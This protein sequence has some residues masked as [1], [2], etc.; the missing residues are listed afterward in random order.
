MISDKDVFDIQK[1]VLSE[2]RSF[3]KR[4]LEDAGGEDNIFES[5]QGR[6]LLELMQ[7]AD[8]AQTPENEDIV[9]K[10][11]GE[12]Q[13]TIILTEGSLYCANGGYPITKEGLEAIC[14][15]FV[16]PKRKN[17]PVI[18]FKGIGFKSILAVTNTP[19]IYW[20]DHGIS[21]SKDKTLKLFEENFPDVL[22]KNNIKEVPVLRFPHMLDFKIEI[23]NDHI[24]K[25]LLSDHATVFKF[26]FKN[27]RSRE[28]AIEKLKQIDSRIL[29]FLNSISKIV[30]NTWETETKVIQITKEDSKEESNERERF[31]ELNA[32]IF[33]NDKLSVWTVFNYVSDLPVS[34]KETLDKKWKD[35]DSISVS[36]AVPSFDGIYRP[37]D[38]GSVLHVYFPTEQRVP[39]GFLL[40]GTFRTNLDRRL[41]VDDDP[42]NDFIFDKGLK[43]IRKK[44]LPKLSEKLSDPGAILDFLRLPENVDE[45]TTEGR[46]WGKL[47]SELGD[48]RFI[49]P[50]E[51]DKKI[52]PENAMISPL[53]KDSAR[54]KSLMP[55]S[56]V[57]R[58]CDDTIDSDIKRRETIEAMGGYVYEFSAL[59]SLFEENFKEDSKWIG[60]MYAVL[61]KAYTY[62]QE[63]APYET[64]TEFLRVCRASNLLFTSDGERI[65]ADYIGKEGHIYFPSAGKLIDPPEGISIRF[66]DK[67][68]FS[69]YLSVISKPV[70]ETF[71]YK[72]MEVDEYSAANIILRTVIPKIAEFWENWPESKAFEPLEVLKFLNSIFEISD[73]AIT[74]QMRNLR[75]MPV[76][77]NDLGDY[78]EASS[79]YASKY[80]TG[81]DDLEVIYGSER[82]FLSQPD[83][84][85]EEES[86]AQLREVFKTLG[87]SFLPRVIS[88]EQDR[89]NGIAYFWDWGSH[90]FT[91]RHNVNI[92][93]WAEYCKDIYNDSKEKGMSNPFSYYDLYLDSFYSL[94][95]FDE[96]SRDRE[97]AQRLLTVL[98]HNLN[99]YF[100]KMKSKVLCREKSAR[101]YYPIYIESYLS[102]RLKNKAWVPTERFDLWAFKS[103][104]DLFVKSEGAYQKL[105]D[106]L[107]AIE[108]EDKQVD[109]LLTFLDVRRGI[110]SVE[111]RDWWRIAADLPRLLLPNEKEVN[112]IY[113]EMLNAKGMEHDCDEKEN[114][115]RQGKILAKIDG[116]YDFV[117]R[118]LVWYIEGGELRTLFED[119]IPVFSIKHEENRGASIKRIF[120]IQTLEDIVKPEIKLG[121]KDSDLTDRF[122]QFFNRLK[123]FLLARINKQRPSREEN[124]ISLMKRLKLEGV[125]QL[126]VSYSLK[127]GDDTITKDSDRGMYTDKVGGTIYI[128]TTRFSLRNEEEWRNDDVFCG[129][130]GIQISH[131]M[132]SDSADTLANLIGKKPESRFYILEMTDISREDV[133]LFAELLGEEVEKRPIKVPV[134]TVDRE[135]END[136][137][138]LDD[139]ETYEKRDDEESGTKTPIKTPLKLWKASELVFEGITLLG[140]KTENEPSGNIGNRGLGGG[141]A[142]HPKDKESISSIEQAGVAIAMAFEIARHEMDHQCSPKIES[143]EKK[144]VGFDIKSICPHETRYIEVKSSSGNMDVI[145]MTS[146]EWESA[147]TNGETAF[148]YRIENVDK[149]VGVLP[150]IIIIKNPYAKLEGEPFR[151]KLKMSKISDKYE[152]VSHTRKVEENNE[153]AS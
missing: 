91:E 129:Q 97:R 82:H 104:T 76:P 135:K 78:A 47:V 26:P 112:P 10:K 114:F 49:P 108:P 45:E 88:H 147:R 66:L 7:N 62:L 61:D 15:A 52:A 126:S 42:L 122:N 74:H 59:P 95:G 72:E 58:F 125:K 44:V 131:F 132:N 139:E 34:I 37:I 43:L 68:V 130:L 138:V 79:V 20:K 107:P 39:F 73:I 146:N 149:S 105:G 92:P 6:F 145:D 1:E 83:S 106:L 27:K 14:R 119:T 123:P 32:Q 57:S 71:I 151:F 12:S 64:L 93:S 3:P 116:K 2:Y 5:E 29:L 9:A 144:N 53:E 121:Q 152:R 80:W 128:D 60:G 28:I 77:I 17:T 150:D 86:V 153:Q 25:N 21:F 65:S 41:L 67:E 141:G 84:D 142:G 23:E 148:L 124:D 89:I 87:V 55:K 69:S 46:I 120:G 54:F 4:I 22:R 101:T 102:W 143:V 98:S 16:S 38:G 75:R 81:N 19:H 103:P 109:D 90:K 36:I 111:P 33:E 110:N 35:T 137:S 48:C 11:I 136:E 18:G 113:R 96:I 51:G 140:P 85:L 127:I 118:E 31:K 117:E 100:D 40:H 24:L 134:S 56:L 13:L 8:D 70:R 115:L 133:A 63:N 99:F 94:D 50:W 30:I